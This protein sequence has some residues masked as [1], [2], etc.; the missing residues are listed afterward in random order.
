[1]IFQYPEYLRRDLIHRP[2][3]IHRNQSARA[4]VILSHGKSLLLVSRQTRLNYLQP[5]VIAG[6]QLRSIQVANFVDECWLKV[7]VINPSTGGTRTASSNPEQQLIIIHVK[8]D[9][10]WPSPSRARVV[11]DLIVEQCIQPTCLGCRPGKAVQNISALA[12]RFFQTQTNHFTNQVVGNQLASSHYGLRRLA[13]C[14]ALS[15]VVPQEVAGRDLRNQVP[16]HDAL[17]LGT[18]TG[19]RWT[20]QHHRTDIA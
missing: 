19:A 15:Y 10:N 20:K 2:I 7:D 14:R 6:H 13:K 18:F 12:V 9:H 17:G 4:L 1:M 11:K 5:I 8:A 3:A 16:F